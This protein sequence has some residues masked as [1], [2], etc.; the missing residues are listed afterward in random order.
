MV[1]YPSEHFCVTLP[2]PAGPM[3][4]GLAA[5]HPLMMGNA[6]PTSEPAAA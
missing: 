1:D 3:P 2:C 4:P 5:M 6:G